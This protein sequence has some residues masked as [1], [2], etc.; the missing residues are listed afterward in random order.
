MSINVNI[1][2]LIFVSVQ[3]HY[4]PLTCHCFHGLSCFFQLLQSVLI[5]DQDL[6]IE[7]VDLCDTHLVLILREGRKFKLCSVA[8]PLPNGKVTIL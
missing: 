5:D 7:D 1:F 4:H 2:G 6:V 3:N 8:L